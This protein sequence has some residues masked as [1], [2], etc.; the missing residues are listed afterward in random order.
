MGTLSQVGGKQY[1][2]TQLQGGLW[3]GH[4]KILLLNGRVFIGEFK[5]LKMS[6]GKL[7]EMQPDNTYNLYQV[8]YNYLLEK[9]I[10]P[11]E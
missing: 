10:S 3:D 2:S 8:K 9:D 11:S 7:Y 5:E 1:C 6:E 4:G